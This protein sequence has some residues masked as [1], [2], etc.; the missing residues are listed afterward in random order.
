MSWL[1]KVSTQKTGGNSL[2]GGGPACRRQECGV[3]GCGTRVCRCVPG[4]RGRGTG[5]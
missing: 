3:C 5:V 4:V 1:N 2:L